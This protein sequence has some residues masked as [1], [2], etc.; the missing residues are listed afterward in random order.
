MAHEHKVIDKDTHFIIDP[1]TM[2]ITCAGTVKSLRCGDHASERYTFEM[3]RYIEGHDMSLCNKVEAHYNN[4]KYDQATRET[5]INKSF[6]DVEGFGISE[7]NEETVVWTWLVSGDATQLN[8][9]LN[10]CIRFA[11][12]TG[13]QIDYQ[14]FTEIY[15]SIPVGESIWNT[16][17]V[18][19]LY[20]DV[21]EKWRIEILAEAGT[22]KSVNGIAPDENGNVKLP[23]GVNNY[24]ELTNK[25]ITRIESLDTENLVNLRDLESGH[26]ILY[27]YFSPYANSDISIN[28]DNSLISVVRKNAGSHI[29]CLD[30]LNAKIV[31]FEIMV[32]ETAE[33]G[34]QYTRTIIPVLDVYALI[35]KVGELDKL[36]TNEKSNLVAAINE[37]AGTGVSWNQIPDKPT[38]EWTFTLEDGSTVTKKVVITT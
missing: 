8:G 22:V 20:A 10:F 7:T 31:F 34:F 27:G 9:T 5:T 38:E 16:E 25:P 26:Y 19:R 14:K 4:I 1:V 21:L 6:D 30:P 15:A 13:D 11:C 36:T 12:M 24:N 23:S 2:E 3:P 35:E 29:I 17:T 33:K 37:V 32:D 28:A 18:A